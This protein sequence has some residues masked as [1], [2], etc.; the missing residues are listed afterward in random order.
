MALND[1][2][3]KPPFWQPALA[4]FSQV[5]A[6]IAAPIVLALFAGKAL[7]EKYNSAPWFFLGLTVVAFIFSCVG[8]VRITM[9][10]TRKI[11]KEIRDKKQAEEENANLKINNPSA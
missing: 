9:K 7:D 6:W 10:Y 5:T 1:K 8:I 11:E 2:E 4:I 3:H